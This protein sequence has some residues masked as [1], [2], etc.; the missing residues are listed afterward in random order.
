M[1]NLPQG[2]GDFKPFDWN[3]DDG[4]SDR[5]QR[6]EGVMIKPDKLRAL[7]ELPSGY[8]K[9]SAP[10][11]SGDICHSLRLPEQPIPVISISYKN[12]WQ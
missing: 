2:A 5:Y 1:T 12:F 4:V 10:P 11:K 7:Q 8:L 6:L 9:H 3:N